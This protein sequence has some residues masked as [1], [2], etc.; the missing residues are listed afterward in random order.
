MYA[1]CFPSSLGLLKRFLCCHCLS[2]LGDNVRNLQIVQVRDPLKKTV[3]SVSQMLAVKSASAAVPIGR[4]WRCLLAGAN[5][6]HNKF[7]YSFIY[8]VHTPS[9]PS[10]TPSKLTDFDGIS[11]SLYSPQKNYKL[12]I[13]YW[14]VKY[15][16]PTILLCMNCSCKNFQ[17]LVG[18]ETIQL[19][20]VDIL[21]R[22][23]IKHAQFS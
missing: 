1:V 20:R 8:T 9:M 2:P 15:R 18:E 21:R 10:H 16:L 11:Y 3:A 17:L 4:C 19:L 7:L 22:V 6:C 23:I 13:I 14:E 12:T 5:V